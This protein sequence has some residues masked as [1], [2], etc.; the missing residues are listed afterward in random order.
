MT[1][2]PADAEVLGAVGRRALKDGR[3]TRAEDIGMHLTTLGK[4]AGY[5]LLGD[6]YVR[7][8]EPLKAMHM[9]LEAGDATAK[10]N[11]AEQA[12]LAGREA[13]ALRILKDTRIQPNQLSRASQLT[14]RAERQLEQTTPQP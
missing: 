11:A 3:L 8:E 1:R 4:G 7:K 12:L 6:L 5:R 13:E 14:R 2:Y 9:Y 10:L